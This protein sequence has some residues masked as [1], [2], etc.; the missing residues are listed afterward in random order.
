MSASAPTQRIELPSKAR[1]SMK[2]VLSTVFVVLFGWSAI[3]V[4]LKWSRLIDAPAD[5]YRLATVM[6]DDLP[7]DEL[8]KLSG[9]MWDS[10]AMAWVGTLIAA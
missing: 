9:L 6:F 7:W 3:S 2:I 10:I 4:D 5:M 8:G 1:D